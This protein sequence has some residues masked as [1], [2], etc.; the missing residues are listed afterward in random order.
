MK[1][2]TPTDIAEM[3]A[4]G[5]DPSVIAEAERLSERWVAAEQVC[6]TIDA[7]FAGVA[8]GIGF[9]LREAKGM[10]DYAGEEA[11]AVYRANDEK[12]D[13]RHITADALNQ[14]EISLSYFNPS[15]MR[16]HLP[17]YLIA[18]LRGDLDFGM[19]FH[20]TRL[21]DNDIRQFALLS[22]AQRAAVRA[23]LLHILDDLDDPNDQPIDEIYRVNI[24][25]TLTGF[26]ADT[27]SSHTSRDA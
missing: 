24:V 10:D 7:A 16:F 1:Y 18:D 27:D 12:E 23:Y 2:P 5:D 21:S 25:R 17:A 9:G 26:W 6:Q 19:E 3:K 20:L 22:S 15:G 8:L 4:R 11:C 14:C 13:W